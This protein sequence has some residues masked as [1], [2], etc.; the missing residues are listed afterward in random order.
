MFERI[1]H[2]IVWSFGAWNTLQLKH[3]LFLLEFSSEVFDSA[4][5]QSRINLFFSTSKSGL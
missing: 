5:E 1:A 4:L 2:I 3:I